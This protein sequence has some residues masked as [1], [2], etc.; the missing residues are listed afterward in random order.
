M[1]ELI[2]SLTEWFK[3]KL[4][5]PLYSVFIFAFISW[6]WKT[7]YILFFENLE[8]FKVTH[9]EYAKEFSRIY[10]QIPYHGNFIDILLHPLNW[11]IAIFFIFTIPAIVAYLFIWQ[12]PKISN[13]AHT[14]HLNYEFKRKLEFHRQNTIF[15]GKIA[16]EKE[17]EVTAITRQVIAKKEIT[18]QLTQ[19]EKWEIEYEKFKKNSLFFSFS[20]ILKSIYNEEGRITIIQNSKWVRIIGA[21]ILAIAD[22]L[23][24]ISISKRDN[25]EYV[26]LTEKGKYFS[27]KYLEENPL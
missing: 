23:D 2:K 27:K 26:E 19:E 4:S 8:Q 6:N 12:L 9:L 1:E 20:S 14:T 5:S 15:Q 21:N 3:E 16:D 25:Y 22:S 17:K 13:L 11:F 7:F 18:N 24:L 10:F